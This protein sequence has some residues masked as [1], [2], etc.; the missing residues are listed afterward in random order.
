MKRTLLYTT[1]LTLLLMPVYALA[2]DATLGTAN[3]EQLAGVLGLDADDWGA[4]ARRRDDRGAS[5]RMPLGPAETPPPPCASLAGTRTG[6]HGR[7]LASR[8]RW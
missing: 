2:E 8:A 4:S 3:L 1:I 5:C 7:R 6:E